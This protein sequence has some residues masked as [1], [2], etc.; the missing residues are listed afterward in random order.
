MNILV[1]GDNQMAL[2]IVTSLMGRHQVICLHPPDNRAWH[3]EQIDADIVEGELTSPQALNQCGVQGADVFIACSG[4]DEQNIVACMAAHRLGAKRTICVLTRSSFLTYTED[5]LELARSLG[6]D[7]VVQPIEQLA[8]E[9]VSIVLVPGALEIQKVAE[10]RLGLFRFAVSKASKARG[11]SLASLTLP[12]G[13]RL[14]HVRRGDDFIV[15]RGDTVLEAGDKIIAMGFHSNL[16]RLGN[17]FR[18]SEKSRE[19]ATIVGGG[20]VGRSVARDLL[21]AG[22]EVKV[23]EL[24][25]DR[26][27][28][29]AEQTRALVLHGDGTD[30][31]FLEN[32]RIGDSPV[33]ITV[34]NSDERNLLVSLVVKQL[35]SARVVTRA[36]RV[37]NEPLFESVG[38]DV[39]RSAKGAAIRSIVTAVDPG[40]S[41]ILAELEHG[42]ACVVEIT[43]PDTL[44]PVSLSQL[45]PPAYAVVGGILRGSHALVPAGQDQLL[46]GDHAFVFCAREDK[47]RVT[48]YFER[49]S[50]KASH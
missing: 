14:V 41:E 42:A 7:Q 12:A 2:S 33:V 21:A 24:D 36:D 50:P 28:L 11:K 5:G 22:W 17:L 47:E 44:E 40:E 46:P 29:V 15:P 39:V 31:E 10:G 3:N 16:S 34:T 23:V 27:Q 37:T 30:L 20:R 49:P 43:L 25:R 19:E 32:E 35:G 4:I 6:I 18:R 13:T 38:V 1:A 48:E 26:C 9:L 8:E 45:D